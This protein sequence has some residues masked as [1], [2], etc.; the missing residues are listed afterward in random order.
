MFN[1]ILLG[2]KL[3]INPVLEILN[4]NNFKKFINFKIFV[5]NKKVFNR[6]FLEKKKESAFY[7]SNSIK[8]EKK[9]INL[10]KKK[11]D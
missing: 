1:L 7:I 3:T 8:N 4:Q 10:I 6:V 11:G 5:T 9:I 2:D